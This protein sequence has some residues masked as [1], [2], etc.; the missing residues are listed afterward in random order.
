MKYFVDMDGETFEVEVLESVEQSEGRKYTVKIKDE[1]LA[2]AHLLELS[3]GVYALFMDH[4]P[5]LIGSESASDGYIELT[6]NSNRFRASARSEREENI[7]QIIGSKAV[8]RGEAGEVK[9]PMPGLIVKIITNEGEPVRKGQ[10]IIV[11][12]A[13]KMENEIKAVLNGSVMKCY[14]APGDAVSKNQLLM[15]IG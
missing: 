15:T 9:A 4:K 14:V 1:R 12:E 11:L 8:S 13:M 2:V 5:F 7:R 6:V 3:G 10:G